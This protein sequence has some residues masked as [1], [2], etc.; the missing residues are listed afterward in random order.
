MHVHL[1]GDPEER[2]D[3]GTLSLIIAVGVASLLTILITCCV[4]AFRLV[5]ALKLAIEPPIETLFV[6]H[7]KPVEVLRYIFRCCG[8]LSP[9]D[10]VKSISQNESSFASQVWRTGSHINH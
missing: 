9:D 5:P 4:C 6:N 10:E 2:I 7:L 3:T 1:K 8:N